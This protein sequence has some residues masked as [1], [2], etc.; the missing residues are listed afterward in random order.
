MHSSRPSPEPW[1]ANGSRW[2]FDNEDGDSDETT[3]VAEITPLCHEFFTDDA[4]YGTWMVGHPGGFVLNQPRSAASK[5]PTLH[6][7]GCAVVA[8]KD[9]DTNKNAVRVCGP[10]ADALRTWSMARGTGEPT[11]CRRCCP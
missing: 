4:G 10:S 11:P 7:V 3:A 1:A 6:R 2:K 8:P 9:T 5:P